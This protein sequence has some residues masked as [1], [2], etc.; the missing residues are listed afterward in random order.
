MPLLRECVQKA[1]DSAQFHYHLGM[2]LLASGQKAKSKEQLEAAL[3][4]NLDSAN[5]QQARQ[6]LAETN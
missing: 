5:T 6:A 2:T 1:P 3:R 4:L